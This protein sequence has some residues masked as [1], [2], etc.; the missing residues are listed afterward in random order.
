[1]LSL[2]AHIPIVSLL[3]G[4][5]SVTAAPTSPLV[6]K[7]IYRFPNETFIENIA[8]L[9]NGQLLLNTFDQGRMYILDPSAPEPEPLILAKIPGIDQLTGI[10]QVAPNVYAVSGGIAGPDYSFV[11]GSALIATVNLGPCSGDIPTVAIA[12][13]IPN[14]NMLN[15]MAALIDTPHIVLSADSKQGRIFRTNTATGEVDVAFQDELIG[16]GPDP[17]VVPLGANGLFIQDGYLY[18]TNSN[19]QFYARVKITA[20]G[21][22]D[23]DIEE[24][25]HLPAGVFNAFDDF[26]LTRDGVAYIGSQRDSLVRITQDGQLTTLIG[27]DSDFKLDSP[28]S[29]ALSADEK[30]AFVVTGGLDGR[31]GQVVSVQL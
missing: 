24:I 15:G 18:F 28:T 13:R 17:Q 6:V 23:G 27:P 12:A 5:A 10:A 22:R 4:A 14:T 26:S 30:T 3:W 9:P 2:L 7:Q 31:G 11:N 19:L 21:D 25:Y 29:V 16:H 8:I 1:M 20:E